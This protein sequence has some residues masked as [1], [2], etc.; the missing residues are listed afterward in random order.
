MHR[1]TWKCG[2]YLFWCC[3]WLGFHLCCEWFLES[4]ILTFCPLPWYGLCPSREPLRKSCNLFVIVEKTALVLCLLFVSLTISNSNLSPNKNWVSLTNLSFF[5]LR[6]DGYCLR[7]TFALLCHYYSL[8]R[9]EKHLVVLPN[10]TFF[11]F[12]CLSTSKLQFA[13]S[14][15]DLLVQFDFRLSYSDGFLGQCDVG[16][17]STWQSSS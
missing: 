7:H 4:T 6:S 15:I 17:V 16:G 14:R 9:F 12:P 5:S 10:L 3:L 11:I 13:W 2:W 1:N 8:L